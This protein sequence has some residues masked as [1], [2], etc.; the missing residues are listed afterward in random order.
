MNKILLILSLVILSSCG[1]SAEEKRQAEMEE[2]RIKK[3]ASEKL[4]QE[5]ANRIAAVTCSIMSETR[6]MDAAVRV[7]K[8]NEA[9]DKIG[10]EP[11]LRG[12][13]AIKEALEWG[14][15][16]KLVLNETY[17]E[18]LLSLKNDKRER[19]RIAAEKRRVAAEKR[20]EEERILNEKIAEN[21]RIAEEKRA[22]E[23]RTFKRKKR[24]ETALKLE[25]FELEIYR[26]WM[27]QPGDLKVK[28]HYG[29][30][31]LSGLYGQLEVVFSAGISQTRNYN[32]S[33]YEN[34]QSVVKKTWN[35]AADFFFSGY[36]RELLYDSFNKWG[37][38]RVDKHVKEFRLK[39][40]GG[41]TEFEEPLVFEWENN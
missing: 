36:E 4:A 11:F 25:N 20:A 23:E 38:G 37:S 39:V 7:E 40:L 34:S 13:N 2:Q 8:M 12:D 29:C 1:P 41:E 31:G 28:I 24:A 19:D 16:Q 6:N 26:V 14:L 30:Q 21:R 18:T 5:K 10:G 15:C 27:N 3:E 9:R 33:C 22:E 35:T 32:F 17:D